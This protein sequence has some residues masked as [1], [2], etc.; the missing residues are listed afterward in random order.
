MLIIAFKIVEHL[1]LQVEF[2]DGEQLEIRFAATRLRGSSA[3]MVIVDEFS[4]A[5]LVGGTIGWR[6]GFTLDAQLA[7]IRADE[8]QAWCPECW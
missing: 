1:V 5:R 2:E 3:S 6:C 8:G 7:R 4:A